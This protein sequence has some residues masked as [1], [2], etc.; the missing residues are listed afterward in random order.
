MRAGG[1][2]REAARGGGRD[3]CTVYRAVVLLDDERIDERRSAE[4]VGAYVGYSTEL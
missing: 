4:V 3:Y 2:A 1:A